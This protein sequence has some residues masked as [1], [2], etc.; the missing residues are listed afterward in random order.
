V[1]VI[2]IVACF[3]FIGAHVAQA[4][5][6]VFWA[7]ATTISEVTRFVPGVPMYEQGLTLLPHLATLDW[8]VGIGGEDE[9]Y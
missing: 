6:I 2:I 1:A 5:L 4:G 3:L 9:F 8:G 7:G